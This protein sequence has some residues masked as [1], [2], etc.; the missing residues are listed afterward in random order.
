M[1]DWTPGALDAAVDEIITGC[2]KT[3]QIWAA[4]VRERMRSEAPWHDRGGKDSA[5]GLSAR[6]SLDTEVSVV[7]GEEVRIVARSTRE[8]RKGA[9]VGAFLEL[10]TRYMHRYDVIWPVLVT[11]ADDLKGQLEAMLR[12]DL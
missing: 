7:W 9:P 4:D 6:Q 12:A 11:S 3:G 5:T 8:T 1:G 2:V 10:G